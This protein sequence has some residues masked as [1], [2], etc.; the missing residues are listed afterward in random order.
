ML[1][2]K[3]IWHRDGYDIGLCI[4]GCIREFSR[5][6]IWVNV[7]QTNNHL[8]LIGGYFLEALVTANGRCPSKNKD[9]VRN[10]KRRCSSISNIS[11]A[12]RS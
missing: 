12:Q 4:N 2:P 7:Y 1:G 10:M 8:K 3:F 5:K 6:I 11:R 9:R